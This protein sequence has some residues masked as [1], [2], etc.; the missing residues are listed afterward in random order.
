MGALSEALTVAL[1]SGGVAVVLARSLQETGPDARPAIPAYRQIPPLLEIAVP[2]R[3][4]R[5]RGTPPMTVNR[6]HG[7]VPRAW[8]RSPPGSRGR[9]RRRGRARP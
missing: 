8:L 7:Y 9:R 2:W 6:S 1:G 5:Q 3:S 4:G